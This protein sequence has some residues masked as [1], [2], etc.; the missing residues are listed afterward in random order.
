MARKGKVT[1]VDRGAAALLKLIRRDNGLALKVGVF[2]DAAAQEAQG[3]GGLS[4]GELAAA[5]EYSIPNGEGRAWLRGTLDEQGPAIMTGVGK[6]YQEVLRRR[7]TAVQALKLT[8]LA[9]V[10]KIQQRM[11]RG[12]PPALSEDYLRRKLEK[13]PG[14]TKPLIASGQFRGSITSDVVPLSGEGVW[15]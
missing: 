8:G 2:G 7:M 11:A 6:L 5:H 4:V 9:V 13:Y 12:I 3:G 1:D 10:G 15:A 14:A